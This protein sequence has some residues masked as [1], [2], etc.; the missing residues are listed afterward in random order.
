MGTGLVLPS[1]IENWATTLSVATSMTVT[2]PPASADTQARVP[3]GVRVTVRGLSPTCSVFRRRPV[4]GSSTE[5]V[6]FVSAVTYSFVPSRVTPTP[7]GSTPTG[8]E[9]SVLPLAMSIADAW[10]ISS[11]DTYATFPS[12]LSATSSG[13]RFAGIVRVIV[14]LA[15]ST[16]PR[17][18][19][20]PRG[21]YTVR[22][23]GL[24]AMPR[25]RLPT[26]MVPTTALVRG[27]TTEMVLGISLVT[28]SSGS[29]ELAPKALIRPS[30]AAQAA[31]RRRRVV[32]VTGVSGSV[33]ED[34]LVD[35]QRLVEPADAVA[36]PDP[37]EDRARQV[38]AGHVGIGEIGAGQVGADEQ[39]FAQVRP[40]EV[41]A[42]EIRAAGID[43]HDTHRLVTGIRAQVGFDESRARRL[44]VAH[45]PD[46][47]GAREVCVGEVRA[48]ENDGEDTGVAQ[49]GASQVDAIGYGDVQV[50]AGEVGLGRD[51]VGERGGRELR[52]RQIGALQA[53]LREIGALE[54]DPRQIESGKV[55]AGKIGG[56]LGGGAVKRR[57]HL[58]AVE[59]GPRVAGGG[60]GGP[61][62]QRGGKP[63]PPP[64]PPPPRPPFFFLPAGGPGR[65]APPPPPPPAPPPGAARSANG[66]GRPPPRRRW[67]PRHDGRG[68]DPGADQAAPHEMLRP[69]VPSPSLVVR[70]PPANGATGAS[71]AWARCT[72]AGSR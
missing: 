18:S 38:G 55:L 7:S 42:A 57:E 16:T 13:S 72:A 48:V 65:A 52:P 30:D 46:Q 5:T 4:F 37:L 67:A 11:F 70:F 17:A 45:R 25:G 43:A 40:G 9:N 66:W 22:L 50:R 20:C 15:T 29:R 64:P 56:V 44:G 21:T 10:A 49:D 39:D 6:L 35:V 63:P 51:R 71:R 34:C 28:Y 14:P 27:E 32:L 26:G 69:H 68:R 54:I 24:S 58:F 62:P 2:F 36:S 33:V 12:G 60:S 23:S 1:R 61:P 47:A 31:A 53:T 8:V 19:A 41:R 3:S 59:A